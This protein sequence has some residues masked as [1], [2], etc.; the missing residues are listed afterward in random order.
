MPLALVSHT[1]GVVPNSSGVQIAYVMGG[2]SYA[3]SAVQAGT[4][5]YNPNT[6]SWATRAPMPAARN[7]T[8]GAGTIS[9]KL[10]VSGGYGTAGKPTNSL[11]VYNPANNTWATR[12]PMPNITASG[13]T[14]VL[15]GKLYVLYGECWD[16]AG[17]ESN[18]AQSLWRYDPATNQWLRLKASPRKHAAGVGGVINGKWYVAGGASDR[19]LDVY[20][21]E[22]NTWAQKAPMPSG[23]RVA[24]GAVL[25]QKLYV[26]GGNEGLMNTVYAY[27]PATNTW[28]TKAPMPTPRGFLAAVKVVRNGNPV[29]LALGGI[30]N[31]LPAFATNEEYDD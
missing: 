15:G 14:A 17:Y 9:G 28:A 19:A 11:F 8:N 22:T 16:C 5:A 23:Q 7:R 3:R 13:V 18:I 6:N 31:S 26:V 10:Y 12:A 30:G 24:G 27:N 21:P 1:A 25:G 29:L 2:F 20:D 4:Y